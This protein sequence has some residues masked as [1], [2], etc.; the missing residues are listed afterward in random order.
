[1]RFAGE[2]LLNGQP[3]EATVAYN[4][5]GY[6]DQMSP[7][8]IMYKRNQLELEQRNSPSFKSEDIKLPQD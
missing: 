5:D 8:E 3:A 7:E 6:F 1:M 2:E 4:P